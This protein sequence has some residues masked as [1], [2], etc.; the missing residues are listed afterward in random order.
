[1]SGQTSDQEDGKEGDMG[2]G[3][4]PCASEKKGTPSSKKVLCQFHTRVVQGL[5]YGGQISF[6]LHQPL[7]QAT[8]FNG[9][10]VRSYPI[11]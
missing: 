10:S 11:F 8:L 4:H 2:V 7:I 1:M 9:Q 5:V 6:S 3:W